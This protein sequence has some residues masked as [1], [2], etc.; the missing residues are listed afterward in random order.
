MQRDFTI[1]SGM[2][3]TFTKGEKLMEIKLGPRRSVAIDVAESIAI[4]GDKVEARN[5]I[6]LERFDLLYRSLCAIL[7]NYVPTSGHPGGS[8][9][10]GRIASMLAFDGMDYDLCY[11]ERDDA[12][13]ISYAAG[14]K[15]MGLYALWALRDEIARIGAP[16]L[17][18]R[19]KVQR[20][21]LEDLL[22]FRR[23]PVGE[24]PIRRTFKSRP[25]DGH[26]TPATPFL[27]LAT[28]ASGV[29]F[30]A[31]VGLAIGACD[32]YGQSAPWVNIIEGEGGLTPGRVS[33]AMAAAA[34][35]SLGNVVLHVD[36]NQASIDSER[37]CRDGET[38]GDYVQWNPEELALLHDWNVVH[39][40]DGRNLCQIRAAQRLAKSIGNGQPTAVV[41]RTI[42][43][44]QYGIE[45]KA[46]HGAG[47]KLCSQGFYDAIRPLYGD[48]VTHMPHCFKEQRCNNG[49]DTEVMNGCLW[50]ALRLIRSSIESDETMV[51]ALADMLLESRQRLDAKARRPRA[52]APSL[53]TVRDIAK[54]GFSGSASRAVPKE[55]MLQPGSSTTLRAELG[56]ALGYYNKESGGALF[57]ASADLMGSTSAGLVGSSFPSG[58]YNAKTNGGSRLLSTGG[59]CEDAMAGI[60]SGISAY[61]HAI[62]VGSSYG[63]FLAPLAHISA[64]LHAIGC[65]A[66]TESSKARGAPMV[67]ICAHAGLKT[68]EDGPT[69]ADPQA[70]QLFQGNFPKGTMITLTPWDPRELWPLLTEALSRDTAVI[71][72][73][74]T[75]PNETIPDRDKLG[76]APAIDAANGVYKLK[77]AR[78]SKP[79]VTVVLQ[80]SE[81]AF[82]FV[83]EA[84]PLLTR[85]GIDVEAYYVASA[86][87]F[88]TLSEERR[89]IIFPD[90]VAARAMGI[91]GF[92]LPTM[93]RWIM[94]ERGRKATLHPFMSGRFLGSGHADDVMKEA[95]LDGVSQYEA[96]KAFS[97]VK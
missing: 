41:Y 91:S 56:R 83:E 87:L 81:V 97:L 73:F 61:G 72:A 95:G 38:P 59:I 92:T 24:T 47:H 60:L 12:D 70:L 14:H 21:R 37:V 7:Y 30:A 20:L 50:E 6:A 89:D 64:R 44:W 40:P 18:P 5:N 88:D 94:N 32:R 34:T 36:W 9:S 28:G 65:Q 13:I 74:V 51:R 76:L 48:C 43:G 77:E 67:L 52:G 96:I 35:M 57:V 82:A 79:D 62:G 15:A 39:V 4:T 78:T 86:E 25:L 54:L 17:L 46:S 49:K 90:A 85:D 42:K 31:S 58:W 55:L 68:G 2:G 69:H 80:G 10:S 27:R 71:A 11:P 23:N 84:L 75:R 63:A 29:G 19:D 66:A 33:E 8:I 1:S 3:R 26:P 53:M 16:E 45:G 93:D 22:A